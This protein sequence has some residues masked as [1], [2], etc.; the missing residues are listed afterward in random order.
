[1]HS[2][3]RP[4]RL[5]LCIT[6]QSG[7]CCSQAPLGSSAGFSPTEAVAAQAVLHLRCKAFSVPAVLLLFVQHGAFRG[8]RDTRCAAHA[9]MHQVLLV[10]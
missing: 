4:Y 10:V 8:A 3:C 7:A 1:M 6:A 9:R 5:S 2:P